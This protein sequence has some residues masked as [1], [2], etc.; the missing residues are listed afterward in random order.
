MV[1]PWSCETTDEK[2]NKIRWY[3]VWCVLRNYS[4]CFQ[5]VILSR[6]SFPSPTS[7]H[8]AILCNKATLRVTCTRYPSKHRPILLLQDGTPG[9]NNRITA[10]W[11][12]KKSSSCPGPAQGILSF[13]LPLTF[14]VLQTKWFTGKHSTTTLKHNFFSIVHH[15]FPL[16]QIQF[17]LR[18][19]KQAC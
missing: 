8:K 13:H 10:P 7:G 14:P 1:L 2:V 19:H 5:T 12:T 3:I 18:K 17:E 9:H 16:L 11:F 4:T 6:V 15:Q